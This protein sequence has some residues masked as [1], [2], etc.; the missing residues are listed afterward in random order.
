[1]AAARAE[2]PPCWA[3]SSGSRIST[4]STSPLSSSAATAAGVRFSMRALASAIRCAAV[5]VDMTL[6]PSVA[7]D[8]VLSIR[9][10]S[11]RSRDQLTRPLQSLSRDDSLFVAACEAHRL[12]PVHAPP[13]M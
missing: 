7:Y 12:Y 10:G 11:D 2:L 3:R 8:T 5:F 6:T 1:M 13:L 4:S 9:F